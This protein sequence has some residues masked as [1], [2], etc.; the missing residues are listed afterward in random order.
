VNELEAQMKAVRAN[1]HAK[2]DIE[3]LTGLQR[4][5]WFKHFVAKN[6]RHTIMKSLGVEYHKLIRL[7]GLILNE[8]EVKE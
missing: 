6:Y 5:E 1:T 8:W 4:C 3:L 2:I 7:D